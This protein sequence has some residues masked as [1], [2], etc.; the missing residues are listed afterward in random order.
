MTQ[1]Q[2][3]VLIMKA[4]NKG[5]ITISFAQTLLNNTKLTFK[6]EI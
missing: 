3:Q 2:Y 5:A 6:K 1:T 4:V